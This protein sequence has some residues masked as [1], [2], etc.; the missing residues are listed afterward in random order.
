MLGRLLMQTGTRQSSITSNG[1]AT[2][3]GAMTPNGLATPAAPAEQSLGLSVPGAVNGYF[4]NHTKQVPV[5]EEIDWYN[6]NIRNLVADGELLLVAPS[7]HR[8]LN[9][10]AVHSLNQT[11]QN[12][13]SEPVQCV[14]APVR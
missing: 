8:T 3:S 10:I 9:L 13:F 2:P 1:L 4:G 7:L 14:E 5:F 6:P 12:L 11:T